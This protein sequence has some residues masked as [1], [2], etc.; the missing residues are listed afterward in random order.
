MFIKEGGQIE[1][2][3]I[4]LLKNNGKKKKYFRK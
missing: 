2:V 1:V 3:N 4:V